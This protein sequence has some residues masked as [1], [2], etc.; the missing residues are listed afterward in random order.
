M[1][2]EEEKRRIK[3]PRYISLCARALLI[4]SLSSRVL[5]RI[6]VID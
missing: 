4:P 3:I 5:R 6:E 2:D 1:P